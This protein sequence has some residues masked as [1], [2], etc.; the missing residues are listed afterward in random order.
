VTDSFGDLVS[1]I[2]N[3]S[4][5]YSMSA[6]II[7]CIYAAIEE[8]E[9]TRFFFNETI[10]TTFSLSASQAVYTSADHTMIPR[11]MEIDRFEVTISTNDKRGLER[12]AYSWIAE[13]NETNTNSEPVAYAYYGQSFHL[14]LPDG[15]YTAVVSV[16]VQLPSLSA[17]TD[18]NAWTQ[19]GNG[20]ELVKQNALARLYSE[21]L[22][23]DANATRAQ[24]R[25]KRAYER[26]V[27][28]T[29]SLQATGTIEPSL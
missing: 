14:N 19:R 12:K 28:R 25:E 17:S 26:L 9:P 3:A 27:S 24:A 13:Y 18:S 23:D 2:A 1:S 4:R 10:D 16:L 20:R 8:Y 6:E 5:R 7:N 29:S 22:R 11:F 15:G 21:F